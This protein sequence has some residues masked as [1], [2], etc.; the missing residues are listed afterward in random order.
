MRPLILLL[1]DAPKSDEALAF[2]NYLLNRQDEKPLPILVV[3]TSS[4][5]NTPDENL[6]TLDR[7]RQASTV[8]RAET[9]RA[10]L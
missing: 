8:D 1:D 3:V 5:S 10:I 6:D 7:P 9:A 4:P 2:C